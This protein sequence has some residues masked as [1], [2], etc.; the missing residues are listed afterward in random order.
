MA[1]PAGD[2]FKRIYFHKI[3]VVP[4]DL[5][6]EGQP[7]GRL[8][9]VFHVL[10]NPFWIVPALKAATVAI[11]VVGGSIGGWFLIDKVEEFTSTG[12]GSIIGVAASIAGLLV[13]WQIFAD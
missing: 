12:I 4:T 5:E 1:V 2:E 6:H 11:G 10:D 3:N 8:T 13:A 9:A 7:L